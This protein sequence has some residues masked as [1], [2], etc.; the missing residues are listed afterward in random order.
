VKRRH[1]V[2]L[3]HLPWWPRVFRDGVTDLLATARRLAKTYSVIAPRLAAALKGSGTTQIID[4]CSGG[5][6]PWLDLLPALRSEGATVSLCLTDKYP[7][8][9]TPQILATEFEA[10]SRRGLFKKVLVMKAGQ[11]RFGDH[12]MAV[13]NSMT[14]RNRPY[15]ASIGNARAEAHVRTPAIVVRHPL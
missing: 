2:E 15:V 12:S 1:L 3:E 11:N 8:T 9:S 14:G 13:G 4:L 6:G 10:A 7:N 5:G